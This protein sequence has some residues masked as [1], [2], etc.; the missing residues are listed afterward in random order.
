[1]SNIKTGITTQNVNDVIK[2][3]IKDDYTQEERIKIS[4][5]FGAALAKQNFKEETE[6][7]QFVKD[8][9]EYI[10]NNLV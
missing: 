5:A 10:H 8:F 9:E 6:Y 2:M 3:L 4:I 1:M 7:Y